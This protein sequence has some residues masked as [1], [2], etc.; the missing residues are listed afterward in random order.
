ML[1]WRGVDREPSNGLSVSDLVCAAAAF[2][3]PSPTVSG[4]AQCSRSSPPARD[5]ASFRPPQRPNSGDR[6]STG[7][8]PT[9]ALRQPGGAPR[10]VRRA[11][12]R[13]GDGE[14]FIESIRK[15]S[16]RSR[17]K[18]RCRLPEIDSIFPESGNKF[19]NWTCLVGNIN[20]CFWNNSFNLSSRKWEIYCIQRL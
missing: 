15:D 4:F 13:R 20:S 18:P 16:R 14:A 11:G 2:P 19:P 6:A 5:R 12:R 9:F 3:P 1:I 8:A 17:R 7:W 10:R